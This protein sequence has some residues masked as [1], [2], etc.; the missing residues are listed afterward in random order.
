MQ[1]ST[2]SIRYMNRVLLL[3]LIAALVGCKGDFTS[4][5][6]LKAEVDSLQ[7]QLANTYKPGLGE[8]MSSIQAHHSKLWFAGQH[9][10]WQ[11]ADFEIHE[12]GEALEN[13]K[14]FNRDRPEIKEIDMIDNSIDSVST[15]IK[16]H[17]LLLFNMSYNTLTNSCN[18]CHKATDHAFNRIITP[19]SPPATDQAF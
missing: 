17:D 14:K 3:F 6:K 9:Q 13:I 11:L 2:I 4:N 18:N 16:K 19:Q 10:N 12:I 7:Q 8:F 1:G 5:K 15:A